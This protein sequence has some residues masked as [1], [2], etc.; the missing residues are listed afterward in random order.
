MGQARQSEQTFE[1]GSRRDA[2]EL[3]ISMLSPKCIDP[4]HVPGGIAKLQPSDCAGMLANMQHGDRW[5]VQAAQALF[6]ARFMSQTHAA[7]VL[8]DMLHLWGGQRCLFRH[9]SVEISGADHRALSVLVVSR[10]CNELAVTFE[11]A[12]AALRIGHDKWLR[13]Q[14]L[15]KDLQSRLDEAQGLLVDHLR[16]QMAGRK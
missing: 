4:G 12:K 15:V 10:Y 16:Q 6:E 7:R 3:V 13:W 9:Q 11:S 2:L 8:A 1:A 5:L 14:P